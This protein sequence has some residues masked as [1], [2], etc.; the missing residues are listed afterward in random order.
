MATIQ[1]FD[2]G[3]EG[4]WIGRDD[5]KLRI[6]GHLV[7]RAGLD[8][9]ALHAQINRNRPLSPGVDHM[10]DYRAV[11]PTGGYIQAIRYVPDL[12]EVAAH[13]LAVELHDLGYGHQERLAA[14]D[15][16]HHGVHLPSCSAEIR[17]RGDPEESAVAEVYVHEPGVGHT[18][19]PG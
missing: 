3:N 8:I 17:E 10:K 5:F 18:R 7:D 14:W 4:V 16:D 2:L 6:S 11:P 12:E 13:V 9:V 1:L 15:R 19:R